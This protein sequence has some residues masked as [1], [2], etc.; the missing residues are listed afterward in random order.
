MYDNR[1]VYVTTAI[2]VWLEQK[3][4]TTLPITLT[5]KPW[6]TLKTKLLPT[7]LYSAPPP[8]PKLCSYIY[9][10]VSSTFEKESMSPWSNVY[11]RA[12]NDEVS[13]KKVFRPHNYITHFLLLCCTLV[14]VCVVWLQYFSYYSHP[15]IP[16]NKHPDFQ[17]CQVPRETGCSMPGW[18]TGIVHL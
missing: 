6:P 5:I 3:W 18:T 14:V 16:I 11:V 10:M 13:W 12:C 8:K 4:L 1:G 9:A 7:P 15:D 2:I 17:V